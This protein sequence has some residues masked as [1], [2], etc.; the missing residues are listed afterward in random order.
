MH[1]YPQQCYASDSPLQAESP[2]H[3]LQRSLGLTRWP[4]FIALLAGLAWSSILLAQAGDSYSGEELFQSVNG[5]LGHLEQVLEH[6]PAPDF[7]VRELFGGTL[8]LRDLRGSLVIITFVDP[9]NENEARAWLEDE[10]LDFTGDPDIVFVNVLFPGRIPFIASRGKVAHELRSEIDS[11]LDQ[12]E[13]SLPRAEVERFRKTRIKWVV[14]W[15]RRLL[16]SFKATPNRLNVFV[17]DDLGRIRQVF[18]QKTPRTAE[19][20]SRM[21]AHLKK[22]MGAGG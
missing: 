6:P 8:R 18:R 19:R 15:K 20:L 12:V 21:I 16:K 22:E 4:F 1:V 13:S 2:I 10:S 5:V 3:P 7:R 11:Y 9:K 17:L 14:D